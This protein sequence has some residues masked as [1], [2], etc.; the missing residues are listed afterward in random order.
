MVV[1][2]DVPMYEP[3]VIHSFINRRVVQQ[4]IHL[5]NAR[6]RPGELLSSAGG[7][8]YVRAYMRVRACVSPGMVF[9][10][11]GGSVS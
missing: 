10:S 3:P 8:Q 4:I 9:E 1:T 5:N 6:G 11:L 7:T 2:T